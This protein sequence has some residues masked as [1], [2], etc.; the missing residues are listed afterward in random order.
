MDKKSYMVGSYGPKLEVHEYE[1]PADEAPKG[2]LSRGRYLIISRVF[3]DD[4]NI[5]L[6]WEWNLDIKKSWDWSREINLIFL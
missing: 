1:S 6:M 3:D 5:H 2:M 4:K